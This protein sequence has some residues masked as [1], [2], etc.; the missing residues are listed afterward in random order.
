LVELLAIRR[1]EVTLQRP[2]SICATS[3]AIS[4]LDPLRKSRAKARP[5]LVSAGFGAPLRV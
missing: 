3:A 5:G 1:A 2:R 4:S